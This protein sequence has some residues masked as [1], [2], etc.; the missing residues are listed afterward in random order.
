MGPLQAKSTSTQLTTSGASETEKSRARLP[1]NI[2]IWTAVR[3]RKG[4]HR[5]EK[6]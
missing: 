4:R 5:Q 3:A 2:G 6:N 1:L